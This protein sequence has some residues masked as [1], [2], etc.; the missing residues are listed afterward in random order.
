MKTKFETF[1]SSQQ[2]KP[3][4]ERGQ[5]R[6]AWDPS[7]LGLPCPDAAPRCRCPGPAATGP[8]SSL[9]SDPSGGVRQHVGV[10]EGS[11]PPGSHRRVSSR[12]QTI[13]RCLWAARRLGTPQALE[14]VNDTVGNSCR[15]AG[16]FPG[17]G[18]LGR[19]PLLFGR[20]RGQLHAMEWGE[21]GVDTHRDVTSSAQRGSHPT[22]GQGRGAWASPLPSSPLATEPQRSQE[23]RI[24]TPQTVGETPPDPDG[25]DRQPP[26]GG[27][28]DTG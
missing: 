15:A 25:K 4:P 28:G 6:G 20:A 5:G 12:E 2:V 17:A 19:G 8:V 24:N 1:P 26:A 23:W 13:A 9:A 18:G 16:P 22:A 10:L 27:G 3:S 11:P 21:E 7:G 14:Q